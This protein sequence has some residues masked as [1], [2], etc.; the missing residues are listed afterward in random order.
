MVPVCDTLEKYVISD[1][2]R[3]TALDDISVCTRLMN[4]IFLPVNINNCS[5]KPYITIASHSF[6]QP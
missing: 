1:S 5:F 3:S 2:L 4:V 6:K